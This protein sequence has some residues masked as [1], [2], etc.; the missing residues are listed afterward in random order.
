MERDWAC[1]GTCDVL[2]M[3]LLFQIRKMS[4]KLSKQ[5]VADAMNQTRES[6]VEP[7]RVG[8]VNK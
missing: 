7:V 1:R 8:R 2:R 5:E 3:S 4:K 6:G